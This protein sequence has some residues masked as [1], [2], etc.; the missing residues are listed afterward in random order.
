MANHY[1]IEPSRTAVLSMDMQAGIVS[2]Y[3]KDQ[4]G[5]IERAA[6]VL[7]KAREL[8]A[9]VIHIKVGFRIGLPEVSS[10]NALFNA[11]KTSEKHQRLFAGEMG[12]IHPALGPADDD[13]VITKHRISAFIGTDLDMILRANEIET[14][15]LFG[16]ATSGVV[17]S[18]LV[19]AVDMDY[20]VIVI[21]DCCTDNEPELHQC[22]IEKYFS[23]RG[24]VISASEFLSPAKE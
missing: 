9:R 14:L 6:S 13:I 11:V 16:I 4:E 15:V 23:K 17:L 22:L 1:V 10:R 20:R 8:G 3:A 7:A 21:K 2:I 12:E 18:T 24:T 19:D 5:F